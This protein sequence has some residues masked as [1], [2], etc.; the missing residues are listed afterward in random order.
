MPNK[1]EIQCCTQDEISN[2]LLLYYMGIS[3][4][5]LDEMIEKDRAYAL[6]VHIHLKSCQ[7][8]RTVYKQFKTETSSGNALPKYDRKIFSR[9]AFKLVRQNE[10]ALDALL[11]S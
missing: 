9:E 1:M 2:D 11:S 8:C 6:D 10:K 7:N 5:P 4:Q 3:Y